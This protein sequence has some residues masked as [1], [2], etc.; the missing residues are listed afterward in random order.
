MSE[1]EDDMNGTVSTRFKLWE[2][3]DG[4]GGGVGWGGG[5]GNRKGGVTA[6]K[7]QGD[8]EDSEDKGKGVDKG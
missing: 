7:C 2:S 8:M 3:G 4:G 1:Y 5:V 6:E